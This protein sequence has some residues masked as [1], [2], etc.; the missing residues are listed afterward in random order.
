MLGASQLE[1]EN[2]KRL[3]LFPGFFQRIRE[4]LGERRIPNHKLLSNGCGF[5]AYS[6]KLPA[7]NGVFLLTVDNLSFFTCSWSFLAYSGKV[8]LIRA[9]RD[10]KQRSSTVSKKAPTVSKKASP[11]SNSWILWTTVKA[12]L[13]QA[14]GRQCP[15]LLWGYLKIILTTPTPHISKN[16]TPKYAIKWGVVWRTNPLKWRDFHRECGA[17]TDFHGIRT[18]T[19]MAYETPP[20]MPNEPFLLGVG[21]VFNLLR[22][23]GRNTVTA[24]CKFFEALDLPNAVLAASLQCCEPFLMLSWLCPY[25]VLR[26]LLGLCHLR[27]SLI[28][29]SFWDPNPH[30][31]PGTKPIHK[32]PRPRFLPTF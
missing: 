18:P 7:Y 31:P 30:I 22:V 3:W 6:W 28:W 21:V 19:F 10:C 25:K 12:N 32:W 1:W 26:A 27:A 16:M 2:S 23:F 11:L 17:R 29:E 24:K 13:L 15:H 9:L 5:F 14:L 8:P 4:S 20:F